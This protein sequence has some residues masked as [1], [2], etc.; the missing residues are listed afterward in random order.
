MLKLIF[1]TGCL[2]LSTIVTFIRYKQK[3]V[4]VKGYKQKDTDEKWYLKHCLFIIVLMVI[5]GYIYAEFDYN[6]TTSYL[7]LAFTVFLLGQIIFETVV[8]HN[9]YIYVKSNFIFL[10]GNQIKIHEL[11]GY[12]RF[13][14]GSKIKLILYTGKE[15]T[16]N[17]RQLKVIKQVMSDNQKILTEI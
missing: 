5:M 12:K 11:K 2:V 6:D 15:I 16:I 7:Y 1:I 14:T 13:F 10:N 4:N 8:N 17:N 3:K 9:R